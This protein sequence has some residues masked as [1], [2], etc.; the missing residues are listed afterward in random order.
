MNFIHPDLPES[1]K[2]LFFGVGSH[3]ELY[4]TLHSDPYEY[5][6]TELGAITITG[7]INTW[8]EGPER[9]DEP[10][11][12][13]P[14]SHIENFAVAC[15]KFPSLTQARKNGFSGELQSGFQIITI[16]KKWNS[17]E[18]VILNI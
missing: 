15:G 3:L 14:G 12:E 13:W 9:L 6:H 7:W 2:I 10:F 11:Q 18:M 8:L 17:V 1:D 5:V 16:G 4:R